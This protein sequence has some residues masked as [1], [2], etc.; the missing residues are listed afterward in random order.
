MRGTAKL[1]PHQ[2]LTSTVAFTQEAI[3]VIKAG[4]ALVDPTNPTA[5]AAG[6]GAGAAGATSQEQEKKMHRLHLHMEAAVQ[7]LEAVLPG[8][9][10]GALLAGDLQL[11][12]G[13]SGL[14]QQLMSLR[15]RDSLLVMM[16]S[17]NL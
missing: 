10:D 17:R 2:V 14:L 13:L 4:G 15:M 8:M 16:V 11:K 5:A 6:A 3:S 12:A 9:S 7:L 1:A